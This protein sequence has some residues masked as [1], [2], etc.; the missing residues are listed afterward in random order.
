MRKKKYIIAID[1][2]TTSVRVVCYD[3]N[4][5]V[6][7]KAQ[8]EFTQHYPQ[9]GWVEHDA[10]EIW[11]V[12]QKL[13]NRVLREKEESVAAIGITNQRETA[14][15]WDK[16][17]GQPIHNAIVWQC[18]RTADLCDRL[19]NAGNE[20]EIRN[21]TGLPIDPYLSGTKIQWLLRNYSGSTSDL[22]F[23]TIDS[24]LIWNM[25]QGAE[26]VTDFTNASRTMCYNIRS[27]QWDS[28]LMNLFNIPEHMMP[29]VRQSQDLFGEY[30]G[31]PITG[32]AGDQQAA[33]FGQGAVRKGDAKNTYGTGCF[34][35]MN[36]GKKFLRSKNGLITTL[37]PDANGKP[38]YAFEGSVFVGGAVVQWLRDELE[39]ID[40]SKQSGIIAA[41][42][43]DT[44]GVYFIPAFTGLGAPHWEPDARGVLT[45]LTRGAN[46]KHIIRAAVESTAY[47]VHD[48][49]RAMEK[50]SGSSLR[51]IF[52]DGGA[53]RDDFLLQF[54]ADI[55]HRTVT[56][57]KDIET[58]VRGAAMLAGLHSGFWD[59]LATLTQKQQH[60]RMF[61]PSIDTAKRKELIDGW[62][63][64][65]TQAK[66]SK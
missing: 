34:L 5:S 42:V 37:T 46:K 57:P 23:G 55:L 26:H 49:V 31:I 35:L 29:E 2:G 48:L 52:V 19:K 16:K 10:Q 17:T 27:H 44:N 53:A 22:L 62:Q 45:G 15:V 4:L 32:V 41:S 60:E 63:N 21:K 39:M 38:V 25:T 56:R 1:A 66:C 12:T 28:K 9:P 30:Q 43:P 13:L 18:R 40:D 20:N 6:I 50:D 14:V 47:Q 65:V 11:A 58:T 59:S 51:T 61:T 7:Q 8:Q 24:W 64:A 3:K 36:I 33:L 54:Q